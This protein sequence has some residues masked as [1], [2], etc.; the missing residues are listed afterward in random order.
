M[1]SNFG[2]LDSA[3]VMI[4]RCFQVGYGKYV[5]FVIN[6]GEY[7]LGA[8]DILMSLRARTNWCLTDVHFKTVLETYF[9]VDSVK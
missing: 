2:Q 5:L 3:A 1:G 7:P 4:M 6:A 8:D 9:Q